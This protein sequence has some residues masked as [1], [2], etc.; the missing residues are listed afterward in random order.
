MIRRELSRETGQAQWLLVSQVE[1]ARVSGQLA[2]HWIGTDLSP[3]V[4]DGRFLADD[5]TQEIVA[6]IAHHDD[7][8]SNWEARPRIDSVEGRPFGFLD[9]MPRDETREIWDG[10]I[11]AARRIGLLAGWIVAGHFYELMN[12]A[13]RRQD[14]GAVDWLA[15]TA[16]QRREWLA[17]W[18]AS[19]VDHVELIARQALRLLQACDFL[20]LWLCC[21]CPVASD[22]IVKQLE[23]FRLNWPADGIGPVEFLARR[24]ESQP[25]DSQHRFHDSGWD[26]VGAPWPMDSVEIRP[27]AGAWL[28]PIKR[29]DSTEE[30]LSARQ[31]ITL[32]WR[33]TSPALPS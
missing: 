22:E 30:F 28:A 6:A 7:G 21:K 13:E 17:E 3:R 33:L 23:P 5:L 16:R 32:H 31:P 10:S 25:S 8:W 18:L 9:E 26:A 27:E 19:N 12:K 15:A 4:C 20:S 14:G 2:R 24:R 1:H 29:Y 11:A